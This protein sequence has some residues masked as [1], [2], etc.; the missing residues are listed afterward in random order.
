[1]VRDLVFLK[2][3]LYTS[4]EFWKYE[5]I[6]SDKITVRVLTKGLSTN[7]VDAQS[8]LIHTQVARCDAH[9]SSRVTPIANYPQQHASVI[10][11]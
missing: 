6:G 1:M 8:Q 9:P 3:A 7:Y 11:G 2:S 10:S 5:K 4:E